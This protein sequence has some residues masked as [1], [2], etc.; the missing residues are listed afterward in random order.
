MS[1]TP[2]PL[3]LSVHESPRQGPGQNSTCEIAS[4]TACSRT[5]LFRG[6][7]Q[8]QVAPDRHSM[9][10]GAETTRPRPSPRM[11]TVNVSITTVND[12]E[13]A[14]ASERSS[15]QTIPLQLPPKPEKA[16]PSVA[17]ASRRTRV[18][19]A[20]VEEHVPPQSSPA[21]LDRIVP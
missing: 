14:F 8:L 17:L 9:P 21:G 2:P 13:T 1:T 12:A 5:P 11:R 10:V 4:G 20:N 16:N 6:N 7:V 15:S 3:I 19:A 18:P